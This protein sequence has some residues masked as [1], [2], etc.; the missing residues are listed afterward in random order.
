MLYDHE[1]GVKELCKELLYKD[2]EISIEIS[3]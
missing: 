1:S 3:L 2:N